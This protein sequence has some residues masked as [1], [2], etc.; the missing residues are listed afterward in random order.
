[1]QINANLTDPFTIATAVA[2]LALLAVQSVLILR[3]K[4]LSPGRK[5]L[6]AALNGLLWLVLAGYVLQISWSVDRPATHALLVGGEVPAVYARTVQ[7]SLRIPERFAA[8]NTY[9]SVTLVGQD[10]PVETLTQLSRSVVRGVPY[11]QPDRIQELRWKAIVRQGEGQ[12]VTGHIRSSGK[13]VLRIRYGNQTLDSLMLRQGENTFALQ[14]PVFGRGRIQTELVLG[15]QP[16]DTV[17]FF[18]RPTTPLRVL[19]VLNNPDFESK[20]LAEWLGKQGHSVQLTTTLAKN[21]RSRTVINSS[22]TNTGKKPDLII[23]DPA[24]A[25]DAIVRNAVAG[26]QAVLFI[27]L[28]NPPADVAAINRALRTRWQVRR[29][30]NQEAIPVGNGLTA[31][32]YQFGDALN[33]LA[34]SGYPVATQQGAGQV[35]VSLLNET[36]PLA[37]S[38]DSVAYNRIWYAIMARLR[39]AQTNNVLLDAPIFSGLSNQVYVNN[40][41]GSNTVVRM[42]TDTVRLRNAP[43]NRQSA[44]GTVRATREG[45]Q[46]VQDSLAVYVERTTGNPVAARQVVN[47]FLLAHSKYQVVGERTDHQTSEEIPGWVWLTLFLVCLTALWIEPK[48]S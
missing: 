2:L 4:T 29:V 3:N 14:F 33:Q 44:I 28:S 37:L 43:L 26:G 21:V 6:R 41:V 25:T 39:P 42:G 19:F 8:K 12:R 13:Q 48:F 20:T 38:G 34:V 45:W 24:N 30:S 23:T 31:L 32:P 27:N 1:M 22:P 47:R 5:L 16:L 46:P 17:R 15:K 7:D 36:F 18:S 11:H 9:D 10:F 35:G 40:L